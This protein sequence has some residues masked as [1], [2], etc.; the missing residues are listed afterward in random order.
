[1]EI[2]S[3]A[4]EQL[5]QTKGVEFLAKITGLVKEKKQPLFSSQKQKFSKSRR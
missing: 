3:V 5:F 1:M 4:E 2:K